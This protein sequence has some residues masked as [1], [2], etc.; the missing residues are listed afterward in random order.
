MK[1]VGLA[2]IFS[3]DEGGPDAERCSAEGGPPK[4]GQ[5]DAL[6]W[7]CRMDQCFLSFY[8]TWKRRTNANLSYDTCAIGALDEF[9]RA[10]KII[11]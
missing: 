5:K 6:R 2:Q 10:L 4:Y 8:F 7:R 3:S 11:D 9:I 1:S